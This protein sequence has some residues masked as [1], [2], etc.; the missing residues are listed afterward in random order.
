MIFD[1]LR[2]LH[3]F[4]LIILLFT[5]KICY[6]HVLFLNEDSKKWYKTRPPLLH[7]EKEVHSDKI[8]KIYQRCGILSRG[9]LDLGLSKTGLL[10]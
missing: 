10:V 2:L 6:L 9:S 5:I 7:K 8:I 3:G 4:N 1:W